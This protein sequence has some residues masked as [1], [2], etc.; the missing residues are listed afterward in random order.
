M[1]LEYILFGQVDFLRARCNLY[2]A[3]IIF[4]VDK[5][6]YYVVKLTI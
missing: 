2:V 5:T 3:D 1:W 6:S 4:Y